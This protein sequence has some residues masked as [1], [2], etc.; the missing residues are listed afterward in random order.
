MGADV[1]TVDDEVEVPETMT[2][3]VLVDV[4]SGVWILKAAPGRK[5]NEALSQKFVVGWPGSPQ[6]QFSFEDVPELQGRMYATP[7][8]Y[9]VMS[10][11]ASTSGIELRVQVIE[12]HTV[13]T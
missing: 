4:A 8:T 1:A 12:P 5:K 9:T 3:T 10:Q 7:S 13:K 11:L 2:V 6:T